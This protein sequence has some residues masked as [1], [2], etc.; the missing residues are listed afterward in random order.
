MTLRYIEYM[1]S[2]ILAC[3]NAK[4]WHIT[5]YDVPG[6]KHSGRYANRTI[7]AQQRGKDFRGIIIMQFFLTKLHLRT[8]MHAVKREDVILL[9]FSRTIY[10]RANMKGRHRFASREVL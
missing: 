2:A 8:C 7:F 6:L 9:T 5:P 10:Y 4:R 1:Q 3:D